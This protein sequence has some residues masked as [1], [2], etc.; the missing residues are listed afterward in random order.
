MRPANDPV[1]CL[2]KWGKE[3]LFAPS[4]VEFKHSHRGRN[5]G[6]RSARHSTSATFAL[7]AKESLESYFSKVTSLF[8]DFQTCPLDV[9]KGAQPVATRRN[10]AKPIIVQAPLDACPFLCVRSVIPRTTFDWKV[11]YFMNEM[12]EN[13]PLIII[14]LKTSCFLCKKETI[15]PCNFLCHFCTEDDT[16]A[17]VPYGPSL[18]FSWHFESNFWRKK[19]QLSTLSKK[20][21]IFRF[22]ICGDDTT[23][24]S[25]N[26]TLAVAACQPKQTESVSSVQAEPWSH[27]CSSASQPFLATF[28]WRFN[29]SSCVWVC[30]VDRKC[31]LH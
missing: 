23:T 26:P 6:V 5:P 10:V 27:R 3:S 7:N 15:D 4:D 30:V 19:P 9:D 2:Q 12:K 31:V 29:W 1:L 8:A 17:T 14:H 21:Q 16:G 28:Y 11:S 22:Q 20:E 13:G 18:S 25:W 24:R